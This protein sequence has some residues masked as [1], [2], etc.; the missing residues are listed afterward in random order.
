MLF[1]TSILR[2]FWGCIAKFLDIWSDGIWLY[3]RY[4]DTV[5]FLDSREC[6]TTLYMIFGLS[7]QW[8]C[9]F[10]CRRTPHLHMLRPLLL[11]EKLAML[12]RSSASKSHGNSIVAVSCLIDSMC[13]WTS[14]VIN[15]DTIR[16]FSDSASG[17]RAHTAVYELMRRI[18]LPLFVTIIDQYILDGNIALSIRQ[19][20]CLSRLIAR[21]DSM[22]YWRSRLFL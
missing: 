9:E 2:R 5:G 18:S 14:R 22:L 19:Q 6:D 17:F 21:S 12:N 15:M 20:L 3:I 8:C 11:L 4:C 13:S 7:C 10:L 16:R 1:M